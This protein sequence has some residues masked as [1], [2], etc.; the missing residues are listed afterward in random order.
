MGEGT[1]SKTS[2]AKLRQNLFANSI[3]ALIQSASAP[4]ARPRASRLMALSM[5]PKL[6]STIDLTLSIK[7]S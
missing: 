6:E 5:L 3:H 4:T 7:G 1:I 2:D